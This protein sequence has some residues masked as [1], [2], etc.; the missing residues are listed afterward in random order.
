MADPSKLLARITAGKAL[1]IQ[2]AMV[3]ARAYANGYAGARPIVQSHFTKGNATRYNWAPLSPAYA[4]EKEGA[5]KAL[6]AG[7][8]QAKRIVPAGKGLPMLVRSGAMR[9]AIV[10]GR[11]RITRRGDRIMIQW[12]GLPAYARYHQDGTPNRPARSP[13]NP[14]A[15]DRALALNA[16][17]RFLS[18]ALGK[19]KADAAPM[20]AVARVR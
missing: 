7:M 5:T 16:A 12:V 19:G 9:D 10:A 2:A 1:L 15:A 13:V 4:E 20:G 3:A 11:A 18:A 6:K 17:R 14:S 8:K